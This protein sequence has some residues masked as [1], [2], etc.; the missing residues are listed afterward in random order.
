MFSRALNFRGPAGTVAELDPQNRCLPTTRLY[1]A[2]NPT[3]QYWRTFRFSLPETGRW[4]VTALAPG[5]D[6]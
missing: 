3:F 5:A 2:S 6:G 1:N 4:P